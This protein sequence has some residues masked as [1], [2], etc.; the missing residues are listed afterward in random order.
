MPSSPDP[1]PHVLPDLGSVAQPMPLE[2]LSAPGTVAPAPSDDVLAC[3]PLDE[4]APR[5]TTRRAAPHLFE[6][7]SQRAG[8]DAESAPERT[9]AQAAGY[10]AG[11][12]N[13][14]RAAKA[15]M[16]GEAAAA[17]DAA[18]QA[19][20]AAEARRASAFAALDAAAARLERSVAPSAERLTDEVLSAAYA[21]AEALVGHD[22]RTDPERAQHVLAH[23]LALTPDHEEVIVRLSP[24]DFATLTAEGAP[25]RMGRPV[26]LVAD[27]VL[28]PGD[29][30]AVSG[31]TNVDA[32]ITAGLAR[33]RLA[34]GLNGSLNGSGAVGAS[35]VIG[36][37][38]C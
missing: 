22:L 26:R 34:L 18:Q 32:R 13:G 36:G 20:R 6:V 29:A 35:D 1:Q 5:R 21:I 30:V 17:R 12:A 33:I 7:A 24:V 11:W 25:P 19:L 37:A 23:V 4:L 3:R 28:Q 31:A 16:A 14:M 8:T 27:P 38:A 15:V 2:D 10:A 9:A